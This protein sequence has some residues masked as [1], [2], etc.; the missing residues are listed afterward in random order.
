MVREVER[1][2]EELQEVVSN[3]Q[4]HQEGN[5]TTFEGFPMTLQ[6]VMDLFDIPPDDHT[7]RFDKF[8]AVIASHWYT[9]RGNSGGKREQKEGKPAEKEG[10]EAEGN[11]DER[12]LL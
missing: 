7:V 1:V 4:H 2:Q 8:M 11:N 5:A 10:D 6:E 9:M 12:D 3:F